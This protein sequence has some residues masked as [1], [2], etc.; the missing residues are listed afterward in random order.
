MQKGQVQVL[1]LAGIVLTIA[2]AGGIFYLGRISAPKP[3]NVIT[4]SPQPSP[5]PTDANRE[6]NGSAE[7]A[8][9]KTYTNTK[10]GFQIKYP[11]TFTKPALP[12]GIGPEIIFANGTEEKT[13]II[14]NERPPLYSLTV[15]PFTGT[16]D[17]LL[18]ERKIRYAKS[19]LHIPVIF[20]DIP[21]RL[22]KTFNVGGQT[23]QWYSNGY[24]NGDTNSSLEI[25]F[26]DKGHGFIFRIDSKDFS[27]KDINQIL[28]TFRFD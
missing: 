13:E 12:S 7:T 28:S 18:S 5:A 9:W 14:F 27:E 26:I 11:P 25:H 10:I 8:N 3:Q 4:S 19:D 16:I 22:V 17:D 20:P 6:P 21:L 15:F 23:A 2:L 1:I 24:E